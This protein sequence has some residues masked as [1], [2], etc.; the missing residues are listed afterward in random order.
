ML[1]LSELGGSMNG[2]QTMLTLSE[3]RVR[4]RRTNYA[5]FVSVGGPS[6]VNKLCSLCQR[7]GVLER[8]TDYAHFV[9]VGGPSTVNK[10]CS[11]CQR[12]GSMN[13]EQ[14]MLT[15]SALGDP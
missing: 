15:L 13:G 14:T 5:H 1:T 4:Q 12:W 3:L 9:R 10:L 7:W 6:K 2:G 8:W 11:L